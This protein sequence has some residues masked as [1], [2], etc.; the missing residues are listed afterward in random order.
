[1]GKVEGVYDRRDVPRLTL[2]VTAPLCALR[3]INLLGGTVL[4]YGNSTTTLVDEKSPPHFCDGM[5][6]CLCA[7]YEDGKDILVGHQASK[8]SFTEPAP[9][10]PDES[11][12]PDYTI[13]HHCDAQKKEET[14]S[15][16]KRRVT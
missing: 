15:L 11:S 3:L 16:R 12:K 2:S 14:E 9:F 7:I 4:I 1:M 8:Q 13:Y 6:V 5:R 10:T